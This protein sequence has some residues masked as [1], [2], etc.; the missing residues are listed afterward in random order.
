VPVAPVQP[1]STY[2]QAQQGVP[3]P[4]TWKD[5]QEETAPP[6]LRAGSG[7]AWLRALGDMKD[8]AEERLKD[9][10]KARLPDLAPADAVAR[11][12][13]ERQLVTGPSESSTSFRARLKAAWDAWPYAGTPLGLLRAYYYAGYS[14]VALLTQMGQTHTLDGSLNLVTVS[15]VDH[16]IGPF[17]NTYRI[18]FF[19]PLPSSWSPTP[20]GNTSDEVSLLRTIARRWQAGH[21]NLDAILAVNGPVWGYPASQTWGAAG[22]WG[23]TATIWT[24]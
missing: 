3:T 11:I 14:N 22:N 17:W 10:V 7:R 13:S 9:A 20:P 8:K 24:P 21:A 18:V 16:E 2:Q 4:I 15:G 19:S 1:A 12:A 6:W 23:S 5:Y